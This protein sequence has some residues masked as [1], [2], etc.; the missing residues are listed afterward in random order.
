MATFVVVCSKLITLFLYVIV[1]YFV[2]K[3]KIISKAF[4]KEIGHFLVIVTMPCLIVST[5]QVEYT[6]ALMERAGQIYLYSLVVYGVSVFIAAASGKIFKIG[7]KARGVWKYSVVFPNQSFMGW[8]VI[9]AIFGTE[10]LFFATFANLAFSTYA[11]TYGV[12]IMTKDGGAVAAKGKMSLRKQL[13]TPI[14]VAIVIGIIL[15]VTGIRLPEAVNSTLDG[16]AGL[17]TPLAMFYIGT[18]LTESSIREVFMDWRGYACSLV[19][20]I[21]VPA[22]VLVIAPLFVKDAVV[23]GVLVLS[24]AMPVAGYCAIY[25]GECGNDVNLASKFIFVP[26][27]LCMVTIP[28]FAM[29]L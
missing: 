29:F 15:L 8:P 3:Y 17:T 9:S 14:N 24:H 28:I 18:I 7:T 21:I 19:R 6:A 4:C 27:L 10:G 12:Y 23:Y 11:Y 22:L 16:F 13:L 5:L 2:C 1:G 20:L 25:A 26:T